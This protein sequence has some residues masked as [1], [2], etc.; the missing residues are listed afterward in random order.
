VSERE[1]LAQSLKPVITNPA[2]IRY[3]FYNLAPKITMTSENMNREL[4][5]IK[6]FGIFFILEDR[7]MI[8]SPPKNYPI[9]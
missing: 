5:S 2:P 8:Q 6:N 3:L 7:T 4:K 1:K 9:P